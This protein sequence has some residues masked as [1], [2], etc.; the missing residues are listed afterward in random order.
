MSNI[1]RR[2]TVLGENIG[3]CGERQAANL[4]MTRLVFVVVVVVVAAAAAVVATDDDVA[5]V[6]VVTKTIRHEKYNKCNY[7][8]FFFSC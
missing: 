8:F 5:F 6:V 7:C 3:I 2:W 1:T 4:I